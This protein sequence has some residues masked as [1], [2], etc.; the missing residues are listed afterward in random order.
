MKRRKF[1]CGESKSF[2]FL[3]RA[4]SHN[5][6]NDSC[7]PGCCLQPLYAQCEATSLVSL[8]F[9]SD[10]PSFAGTVIIFCHFF[11]YLVLYQ[12]ENYQGSNW[13]GVIELWK[14]MD[15]LTTFTLQSPQG[16]AYG[17]YLVRCAQLL[18]VPK[19]HDP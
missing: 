19:V 1:T 13:H 9:D 3:C 17:K 15:E 12:I 11:I 14:E 7:L 18:T 16:A 6:L 10:K 5:F 4:W 2:C 8:N